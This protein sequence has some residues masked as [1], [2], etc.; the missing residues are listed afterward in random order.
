MTPRLFISGLWEHESEE[1]IRD[2]LSAYGGVCSVKLVKR[3]G[4]E[5][6]SSYALVE[7]RT[8]AEAAEANRV[9]NHTE[10]HGCKICV[11]QI[12]HNP[13]QVR[14]GLTRARRGD[15]EQSADRAPRKTAGAA[16][17]ADPTV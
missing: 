13:H 8:A 16:P 6:L 1:R 10:V 7:M 15:T 11:V 2:L 17:E 4:T 5:G 12:M 9:L 3:G 14:S